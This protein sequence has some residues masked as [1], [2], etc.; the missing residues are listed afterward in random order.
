MT[1]VWDGSMKTPLPGVGDIQRRAH[2]LAQGG[3]KIGELITYRESRK[4]PV[5]RS[6]CRCGRVRSKFSRHCV[7]CTTKRGSR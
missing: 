2:Y 3:Y 4:A 5:K 7:V 6:K 1:V